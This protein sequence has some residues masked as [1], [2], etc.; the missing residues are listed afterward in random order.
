MKTWCPFVVV[1][2]IIACSIAF[3]I[4]ESKKKIV[5][6]PFHVYF[7][8]AFVIAAAGL[9][10]S[11]YLALSHYRLYT[12]I[13]YESFC[14]ISRAI[15]C[16]T[17]SQSDYALFFKVPLAIWGM[18]GYLAFMVLMVAAY[19]H[20]PPG[21]RLWPLLL[22]IALCFSIHSIVLALISS[23]IIKSYCIMCITTYVVNFIL[24]FYA[25]L[26]AQR[27]GEGAFINGLRDDMRYVWRKKRASGLFLLF[28]GLSVLGLILFYPKYWHMEPPVIS[29]DVPT[30]LTESGHPWM[31]AEQPQLV[32]TEFADYQC[33]QCQKMHY[34]LRQL[35]SKYPDK[36]RIVHRHFPMDHEVNPIVPHPYHL[37]SG[38]LALMAIY[39]LE[40]GK[41][42]EMN[43]QLFSLDLKKG[44]IR[45]RELA[46]KTGLNEQALAASIY[47]Q[48][49]HQKLW[50]DIREGIT[51]GMTG[52][53]GYIIDGQLY[54]GQIPPDKIKRI[55]E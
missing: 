52:T 45:F 15:N 19:R 31:G 22:V 28:L 20:N 40:Q 43:D 2:N 38:R 1:P 41:F 33:Y 47:E 4:M 44:N 37:G 13:A 36:L 53:P 16:D 12:D 35:V 24:L 5:A 42:W 8:P 46:D 11:S 27:F 50:A 6:L 29:N 21:A 39:A 30:G 7:W 10:V 32:I 48:Q 49:L 17:V 25:Y 54:F 14:A 26:I 55:I 34:F 18:L 51:L 3:N 9:L 23:L